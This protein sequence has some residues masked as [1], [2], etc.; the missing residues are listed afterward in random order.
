MVV[1]LLLNSIGDD[2][3]RGE[4]EGFD[5]FGRTST[6]LEK[7]KCPIFIELVCRFYVEICKDLFSF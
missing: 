1:W 7:P 4:D 3:G 6:L 5:G 2:C